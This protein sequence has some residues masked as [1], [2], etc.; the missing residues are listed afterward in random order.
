MPWKRRA[1]SGCVTA[2]SPASP[3][4]GLFHFCPTACAA[5]YVFTRASRAGGYGVMILPD[6]ATPAG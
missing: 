3:A 5:G 6:T 4:L 1:S 2:L